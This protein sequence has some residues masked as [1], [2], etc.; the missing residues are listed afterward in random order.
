LLARSFV[1]SDMRSYFLWLRLYECHDYTC[2]C[3][4]YFISVNVSDSKEGVWIRYGYSPKTPFVWRI[5]SIWRGCEKTGFGRIQLHMEGRPRGKC[6]VVLCWLLIQ[7][8]CIRPSPAQGSDY[9]WGHVFMF[10]PPLSTNPV[11]PHLSVTCTR[12]VE[13]AV[14]TSKPVANYKGINIQTFW[15]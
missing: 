6:V 1:K 7:G 3:E 9:W 13:S 15:L 11:G 5:L 12:K 2:M 10:I 4:Y 14:R 8:S